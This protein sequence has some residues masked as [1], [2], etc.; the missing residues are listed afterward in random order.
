MVHAPLA[1]GKN[2]REKTGAGLY[3]DSV[4]EVDWS[5]GE[6]LKTLEEQKLAS[7]TLVILLSDNGGTP[8]AVNSPLRGN[9]GST[10]E[11]GMRVPA[12]AWW[13]GK[14]P[15]G[16]VCHDIV[17]NMDVLPTF[18]ALAGAAPPRD[19]TIDGHDL[20]A[21]LA[22]R[23]GA[24]S[25]YD[26]FYYYHANRLLGVR[27]GNWKLHTSGELYDL[28]SDIGESRNVAERNRAVVAE[29]EKLLDLA[30]QDLG[31]GDKPGA[32]CRPVGKA[33]GPLRFWIPRHKD[34]GYPPHAPVK[35]MPGA[36]YST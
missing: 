25:G 24:R 7:N 3:A 16:R 31:D 34:S 6:I 2:W 14:V 11:G 8:R 32:G 17:S 4:A 33:K 21:V 12:I 35:R 36:P 20:S 13:P 23:P 5:T 27:Q 30:R 1:A 15:A 9:K 18:A 26:R 22:G 29:L 19:R 10:W 28:E